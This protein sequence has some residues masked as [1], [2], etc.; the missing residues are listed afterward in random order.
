MSLPLADT[1]FVETTGVWIIKSLVIFAFVLGIVPMIL[2]LERK[3][4][5]PLPEP[6]RAQP[7][8]ARTGCCSRSPTC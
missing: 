2:L 1:S 5:G 6:L 3:L 8:R 7:R 4:L